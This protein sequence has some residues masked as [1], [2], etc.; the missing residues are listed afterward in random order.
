MAKVKRSIIQIDE[1]KCNGCAACI[2]GCPEGALKIVD[3]PKGPKVRL[4]KENFCD[5]LGACLGNCPQGALKVIEASADEYDEAG[6]INHIRTTVP[7]KLDQHLYHMKS[8]G[9]EID[10]KLLKGIKKAAPCACPGSAAASWGENKA[11]PVPAEECCPRS[12]GSSELR[13]W[14]VQL[15]L[16]NPRAEY[17]NEADLLIAADCVP[18]SYPDFHK[19]FLKGKSL[20]VGC[21]KLDDTEQYAEKLTSIFKLNSV[22]SVT[23]A[24]MEVP[25]CFGLDRLVKDAIKASGKRIPYCKTVVGIKGDI[26]KE[27]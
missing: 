24:H 4:A 5:G 12:S 8:H 25:C 1:E 9:I 10:E 7:E 6:V 26:K 11:K 16:V 17:F 3:T 18:F 2:P 21:P 14:P 22:K 23:V 13:H 19:E 27:E 20:V 15:M